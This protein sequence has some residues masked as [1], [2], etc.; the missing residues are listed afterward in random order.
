MFAVL[1]LP[2]AAAYV[3]PGSAKLL[4]HPKMRRAA[5]HF[6]IPWSRYRLLGIAELAAAAGVLIGIWGPALG[7]AAAIGMILLLVGALITHRRAGD[8]VKEAVPALLVLL[9]TV[10][11]LAVTLTR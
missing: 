2:L 8:P 7:A 10:A 1:T 11:Y 5:A 6:G 4:A 9:I 3:L